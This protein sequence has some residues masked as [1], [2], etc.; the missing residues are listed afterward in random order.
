MNLSLLHKN[1]LVGGASAGIGRAVASELAL[2][3]ANV[4][5]VART[6]TAL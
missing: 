3:G 2:L 4:T 1:A 5:L 6:E